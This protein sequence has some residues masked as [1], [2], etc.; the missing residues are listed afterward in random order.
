MSF[1][2]TIEH[3]VQFLLDQDSALDKPGLCWMNWE[4][5]VYGKTL[6][7]SCDH[8]ELQMQYPVY[9]KQLPSPPS[10][11]AC[12]SVFIQDCLADCLSK[13]TRST[14]LT[15]TIPLEQLG[16]KKIL[17][18]KLKMHWL[19]T[20]MLLETR[21]IIIFPVQTKTNNLTECQ[22]YS[23]FIQQNCS[24]E[25]QK[26]NIVEY[27]PCEKEVHIGILLKSALIWVT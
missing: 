21:I 12:W 4:R 7:V 1:I 16:V 5:L 13:G 3:L 14:L 20:R 8:A 17:L 24:K 15:G 26:V 10:V 25:D 22:G 19:F 18:T 11:W 23:S 9:R 2:W 27:I 6:W